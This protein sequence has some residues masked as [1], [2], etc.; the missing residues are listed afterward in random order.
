MK[1]STFFSFWSSLE[2]ISLEGELQCLLT[3]VD[4]LYEAYEGH[5]RESEHA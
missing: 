1:N 5:H 4:L 2:T 3:R